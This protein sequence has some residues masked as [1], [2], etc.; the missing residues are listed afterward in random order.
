MKKYLF[1]IFVIYLYINHNLSYADV[2]SYRYII[3]NSSNNITGYSQK[4]NIDIRFNL[5]SA[6][7][8]LYLHWEPFVEIILPGFCDYSYTLYNNDSEVIFH[9]NSVN[10]NRDKN[11]ISIPIPIPNLKNNEY[12]IY[13]LDVK[14]YLYN[15]V[16]RKSK[17]NSFYAITESSVSG[18]PCY[19]EDKAY[20]LID[21]NG[22]IYKLRQE[23]KLLL[24][25]DNLCLYIDDE[26]KYKNKAHYYKNILDGFV[27]QKIN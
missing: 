1:I 3:Q 7:G 4:S 5:H 15:Y 14:V 24:K 12:C 8:V 25:N 21:L 17:D 22:K 27:F 23:I 26:L 13:K 20:K 2:I 18:N 10:T 11:I 19:I 6:G 9:Y 16:K